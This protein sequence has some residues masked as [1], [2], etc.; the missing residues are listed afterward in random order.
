MKLRMTP[1]GLIARA[2][3]HWV[4]VDY[5]GDLL[6]FL[7]E[8]PAARR[9]ALSERAA[10]PATAGLPFRPRSMRA[11]MLYEQHVIDSSR[12]LAT[13]FFP[14]PVPRVIGAYETLMRRTFP[15]LRPNA[16]FREAPTFYVANHAAVLAD[17]QD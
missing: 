1:E 8:T 11:F 7:A 9:A 14:Q 16:R 6:A 2:D 15:K 17:G 5:D 3:E 13:K 4:H 12:V 10:D